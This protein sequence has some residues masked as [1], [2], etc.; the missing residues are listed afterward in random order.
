MY[1]IMSKGLSKVWS[2]FH[3]VL[4]NSRFHLSFL[5]IPMA[6]VVETESQIL[7]ILLLCNSLSRSFLIGSPGVRRESCERRNEVKD[8]DY[9]VLHMFP[10][11]KDG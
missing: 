9:G 4:V 3:S 5:S 6:T 8:K 1:F 10:E 11:Y 7:G 2:L